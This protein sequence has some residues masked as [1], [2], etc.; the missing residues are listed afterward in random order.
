MFESVSS[1]AVITN[2]AIGIV[3][4]LVFIVDLVLVMKM[5]LY[6][7]VLYRLAIYQVAASIALSTVLSVG[8]LMIHF[9]SV[10][11]VVAYSVTSLFIGAKFIT[12]MWLT[13]HILALALSHRNF[14]KLE[15]L[16]AVSSVV[17]PVAVTAVY[18]TV[19]VATNC[20]EQLV[21]KG[22]LVVI[23]IFFGGVVLSC[24]VF[25]ATIACLLRRRYCRESETTAL[26]RYH[27]IV[28][29]EVLPLMG[30]PVL[31][32]FSVVILL[33]VSAGKSVE[34]LRS[35]QS[36]NLF[37]VISQCCNC[38]CIVLLLVHVAVV[39]FIGR[40]VGKKSTLA[41]RPMYTNLS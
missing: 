19:I 31:L 7:K 39:S 28:T 16:Y 41:A 24:G 10:R 12:I 13:I 26:H 25:V 27:K 15:P 35:L 23:F 6:T 33:A 2:V 14:A 11:C 22:F 36:V 30:Y 4:I 40:C 8:Y 1:W 34:G 17:I 3:S 32:F 37:A 21:M 18:V 9:S 29:A 38:L 5:K 20:P